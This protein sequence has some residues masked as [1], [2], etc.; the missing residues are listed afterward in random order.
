MDNDLFK[1]DD[2]D[3]SNVG[4]IDKDYHTLNR[5][6]YLF[7]IDYDSSIGHYSTRLSIDLVYLPIGYYTM[8]PID[9]NKNGISGLKEGT[10]SGNAVTVK[11]LN[12]T[13]NSYISILITNTVILKVTFLHLDP[14]M[15]IT[16]KPVVLK[17]FL[18]VI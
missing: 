2:D 13:I 12:D 4:S 11:Q 15:V 3:I 10:K 5:K 17:N 18:L 16:L 14:N 8:A 7:Y 6:T 1:E 9:L